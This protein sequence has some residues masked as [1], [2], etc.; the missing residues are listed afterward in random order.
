M[1]VKAE[2]ENQGNVH[3]DTQYIWNI[4]SDLSNIIF[5]AYN[6]TELQKGREFGSKGEQQA[7]NLIYD[8]MWDLDLNPIKE[9]IQSYPT[10]QID[11]KLEVLLKDVKINGNVT[12][13]YISPR[14]NDAL[15][16]RDLS[17]QLS[18]E[19]DEDQ[20][21]SNF[22]YSNLYVMQRPSVVSFGD[23][24][25]E[26]REGLKSEWE[27][28]R[29]E[30]KE[31]SFLRYLFD[32][33]QEDKTI[34]FNNLSQEKAREVFPWFDD[35]LN[36]VHGD[37]ILIDEDPWNNPNAANDLTPQALFF[38]LFSPLSYP[39]FAYPNYVMLLQL[40]VMRTNSSCRGLILYD[41]NNNTHDMNPLDNYPL[42]VIFINKSD[43]LQIMNNMST[44]TIDFYVNQYY[45]ESVESYNVIGTIPGHDNS[46]TIIVSSLMDSWWNPGVADSA[47]G[48]GL[49]L[50]VAKFFKDNN[51]VP[52]YKLKFIA[53]GGEEY[54]YLGAKSYQSRHENEN[55][56]GVI[57]L[58]QLG[59]TQNDPPLTMDLCANKLLFKYVLGAIAS[60]SGYVERT[61][62]DLETYFMPAGSPSNDAPFA[63]QRMFQV[64]RCRTVGFIKD[65]GWVL[66]H[67]DGLDHTEGDVMKYF[68]WT[69]VNATAD[70]VLRTVKYLAVDPICWFESIGPPQ[71]LD[72]PDNID[73]NHD[74]DY[75][76]ITYTIKTNVLHDQV[77]VRALL[78]PKFTFLHPLYPIRFRYHAE[79]SYTINSTSGVT[80]TISVHLPQDA[81]ECEYNLDVYLLDSNGDNN[82]RT[83]F[84][85]ELILL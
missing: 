49:M 40:M 6:T 66:H 37:Y 8:A 84:R 79:K 16:Y 69:D 28:N 34:F 71:L 50:S 43:G 55:I 47:I 35:F 62:T 51:I 45:N 74:P 29:V 25:T 60:K 4:T 3:L 82:Q 27:E 9:R 83:K 15:V 57:D 23:F 54:G 59:F 68:N 77:I 21:S 32:R 18:P 42:P 36:N 1:E 64:P 80:D 10:S 58:N 20:L 7:A 5:Q 65:R 14:W 53:F 24:L 19:F 17:G 81:P 41:F 38:N 61:G 73:I 30:E 44:T 67:R 31:F 33:F 48:C 70:L 12:D 46:R 22:N 72:S 85:E 63:R 76:N 75:V 39:L 13:S 2:V 11:D 56:V 52:K 26:I 78:R